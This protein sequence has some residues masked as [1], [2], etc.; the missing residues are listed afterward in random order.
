MF[1]NLRLKLTVLYAGL[2][3]MALLVIG[4]TA[5][6]VVAG[7]TQRVVREQLA[8]TGAVFD[9][10]WE[11]R[12]QQLQ[13]GARLSAGDYGFRQAVGSRD[14]ATIRSAL[15]NLKSRLGADLVFLVTAEGLMIGED[16]LG[17]SSVSPGLQVALDHEDAPTG[18]LDVDGELHQTVTAP[19]YAPNLLGWV[20]V[21]ERLD[22][23][24]MRSLEHLS[25]IPLQASA[26]ARGRE[27]WGDGSDRAVLTAF[28]DQAL[29]TQQPRPGMLEAPSGRAIALVKPFHTLDGTRSVLLLRYPLSS[30]LSP[31]RAL[32]NSLILIGI[33]GLALIVL[34]T[35]LL[36]GGITQP[37]HS[38]EEAARKLQQGVYEPVVVRTKDE[39][40]RLADSFNAMIGAIKE[41]EQKI[42]QLAYHDGETRLPNRLALERR[43]AATK[44]Q[45][46][47]LAA[48]G[49]DRFAHIRGAIGYAHAGGIIRRLGAR[50]ARLVPNAPMARLSNEV[51]AVAFLADDEADA[52]KRCNALLANLEQSVSLEGHVVDVTISIGVAWP[53]GEKETPAEMI[54][55]ASIALDQARAARVNLAFFDEAAYG[56]PARNLSLMGEMRKALTNGDIFLAHQAK[57]NFRTLSIDSAETLVRWKHP[58]RGMIAPDLFVPMAE[59]T[60]HV[61]ALTEWVLTRAIAEQKK[62][63]A[64]GYPLLMSINISGRLLGDSE[65]MQFAL[66]A[67]KETSHALCFEITETAVIED[68]KQALKNI[69]LLAANGVRISID[70]YGSG[71]SS[72]SYLKQLPAHELK[73]DK[74]FIQSLTNSQR[75][76]LLVRST[77][78]LAHGLGMKVTA[79]GVENPAAFAMLAAMGCD[80]AQGYLVSRPEPLRELLTLL[81]DP[82]RMDYYQ[83]AIRAAS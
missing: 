39:L 20:V 44:P 78:D 28:I 40:S 64:A 75:D 31:Y 74:V 62:L 9:R 32:F 80:M 38:L 14:G 61:R 48:I 12:F 55:L 24:Q 7:N 56:D 6:A 10:I 53:R 71:L 82:Q 83:K 41:R 21:G 51:L 19:I 2:F 16:G 3:C 33:A 4:A 60:G 73:I 76:A 72:L 37:L 25:A 22:D 29:Q 27:G 81:K 68:P 67:V 13:D 17:D 63:A 52:R 15:T 26:L 46:L 79:E 1:R 34:G 57:Y 70:D 47:F 45:R 59:E 66:K 54:E 69:D 18:I 11:L 8:S 58:T 43:L 42:M 65:F 49:I 35:W 23:A 5:Y 50:L 30:A 36:A 77:I